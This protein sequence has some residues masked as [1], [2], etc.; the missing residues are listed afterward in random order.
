MR[1]A[2]VIFVGRSLPE[3]LRIS[4]GHWNEFNVAVIRNEQIEI[5]NQRLGERS[6]RARQKFV[7]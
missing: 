7:P 6:K 5:L 2:L 1:G 3:K 4:Y